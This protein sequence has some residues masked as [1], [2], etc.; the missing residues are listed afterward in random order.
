MFSIKRNK[1]GDIIIECSLDSVRLPIKF[2]LG[3]VTR[4]LV[5]IFSWVDGIFQY[6]VVVSSAMGLG[7]GV[8]LTWLVYSQPIMTTAQ[9]EVETQVSQQFIAVRFGADSYW[10]PILKDSQ[11]LR[12]PLSVSDAV[13]AQ[14]LGSQV[15]LLG[16]NN[17]IYQHQVVEIRYVPTAEL[18]QLTTTIPGAALLAAP[19]SLLHTQQIVLVLR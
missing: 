1:S 18:P 12:L 14:S 19:S 17:G 9:P 13:K 4:R 11:P 7:L 15:E 8:G 3:R 2:F 16:A 6:R 10:I 5:K